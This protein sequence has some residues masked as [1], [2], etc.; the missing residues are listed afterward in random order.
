M[1]QAT[2]KVFRWKRGES[3]INCLTIKFMCHLS[4]F[5]IL[6]YSPVNNSW[7]KSL[8][9]SLPSDTTLKES[10]MEKHLS[11]VFMISKFWKMMSARNTNCP[12]SIRW[13]SPPPP[14]IYCTYLKPLFQYNYIGFYRRFW[15]CL[16]HL[17]W[18]LSD[19]CILKKNSHRLN[20]SSRWKFNPSLL[21]NWASEVSSSWSTVN[22]LT[23]CTTLV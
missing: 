17:V 20:Q 16:H 12:Y 1:D 7:S 22:G 13:T 8:S 2:N 15:C 14:I 19:K 23:G 21:A 10:A 5:L 4:E 9:L 18:C 11:P 6:L 3:F